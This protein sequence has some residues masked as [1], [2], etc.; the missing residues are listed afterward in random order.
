MET[1]EIISEIKQLDHDVAQL[2][3]KMKNLRQTVN[4]HTEMHKMNVTNLETFWKEINYIKDN[5]ITMKSNKNLSHEDWLFA[6]ID[7][8]VGENR[9]LT[10]Q[11]NQL[12]TVTQQLISDIEQLKSHINSNNGDQ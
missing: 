3:T 7:Y 5:H 6:K 1:N 4:D 8:L 9:F 10:N 11:V 12:N 2:F